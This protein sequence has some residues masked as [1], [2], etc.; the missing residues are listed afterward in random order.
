MI[1]V[2]IFHIILPILISLY[3]EEI[4]MNDYVTLNTHPNF[5]F[6][7]PNNIEPDRTKILTFIFD[8]ITSLFQKYL[9]VDFSS[10]NLTIQISKGCANIPSCSRN[11]NLIKL[12]TDID[13]WSQ[14]AY[15][16]SHE[17]CHF[18]IPY[19]VT[20]N[21]RWFEES[22]CEMASYFFLRKLTMLWTDININ[23][24]TSDNR[25]YAP[26][27][28]TYVIETSNNAQAFNLHDTSI[29]SL[30][31]KDCY[32]RLFNKHVANQLLPIFSEL[33]STWKAVPLLC[34][35][36]SNLKIQESIKYWIQISPEECLNGLT[37]IFKLFISGPE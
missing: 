30:L 13:L 19:D 17:L 28:T 6:L 3:T 18:C 21:L 20:S 1:H 36:P 23:L 8:N 11:D 15:Q 26:C 14:A 27:F 10:R 33:T 7:I 24:K 29:I 31:E 16:F 5:K 32:Q 37:R 2:I 35:I 4:C 9:C 25:L 34:H 12:D 22:I